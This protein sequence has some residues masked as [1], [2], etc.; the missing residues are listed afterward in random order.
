MGKICISMSGVEGKP[1]G[2]FGEYDL[3]L[4]FEHP[5]E[6]SPGPRLKEAFLWAQKEALSGTGV[7][8][9]LEINSGE[10]KSVYIDGDGADRIIEVR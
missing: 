1:H 7:T 8:V 9:T 6:N 10:K 3:Y 2:K 5:G 4:R